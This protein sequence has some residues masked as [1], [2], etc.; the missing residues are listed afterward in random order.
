[1]L[2]KFCVSLLL[3]MIAASAFSVFAIDAGSIEYGDTVE[4]ELADTSATAEYTFE[5]TEDDVVVVEMNTTG[6]QEIFSPLVILFGPD[7][8]A[9]MASSDNSPAYYGAF[10]FVLPA[11]GEYTIRASAGQYDDTGGAYTLRLLKPDVLEPTDEVSADISP[12][13]G[14][15]YYIVMTEGE[16]SVSFQMTDAEASVPRFIVRDASNY[17]LLG[18]YITLDTASSVTI[19]A[20]LPEAGALLVSVEY[21]ATDLAS[22]FNPPNASFV[23]TA[24]E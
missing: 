24:E 2:R 8:G 16:S 18:S 9:L 5:G 20:V 23:V 7:E 15:K 17:R 1:M 12:D 13:T 3:V 14:N 21:D 4:G 10:S 6:D 22:D 19:N 11:D